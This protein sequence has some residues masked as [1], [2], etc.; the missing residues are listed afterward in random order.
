LFSWVGFW[1]G[2]FIAAQKGWTFLKV[3]P[4]IL[5]IDLIGAII[6]IVLGFWLTNFKTEPKKSR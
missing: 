4:L 5:G 2:Q 1:I 3:G 6:M